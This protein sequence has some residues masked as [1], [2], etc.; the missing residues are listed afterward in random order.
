MVGTQEDWVAEVQ[1]AEVKQGARAVRC[2]VDVAVDDNGKTSSPDPATGSVGLSVASPRPGP[3]R[4]GTGPGGTV[5]TLFDDGESVPL[6]KHTWR[7]FGI[8]SCSSR[9]WLSHKLFHNSFITLK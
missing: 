5:V 3:C 4:V 6:D 8:N 7:Q 2:G 1:H 9:E